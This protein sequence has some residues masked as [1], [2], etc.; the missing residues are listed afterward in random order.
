MG[1]SA[2]QQVE[3][4]VTELAVELS[5]LSKRLFRGDTLTTSK[6]VTVQLSN[7]DKY[8]GKHQGVDLS[9]GGSLI[10]MNHFIAVQNEKT[11]KYDGMDFLACAKSLV[12]DVEA[13][14]YTIKTLR[15]FISTVQKRQ[16]SS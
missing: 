13:S 6:L 9:A 12:S 11:G 1:Q 7:T 15:L 2:L 5:I 16:T 8:P 3:N 10:I 14:D 4:L